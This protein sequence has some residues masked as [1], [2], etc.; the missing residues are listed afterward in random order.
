MKERSIY[1]VANASADRGSTLS[2]TWKHSK[3]N[4]LIVRGKWSRDCQ[5]KQRNSKSNGNKIGASTKFFEDWSG[6]TRKDRIKR[7][8]RYGCLPFIKGDLMLASTPKEIWK[9]T[10]DKPRKVQHEFGGSRFAGLTEIVE[11]LR[12]KDFNINEEYC[13][14]NST[15]LN[16]CSYRGYVLIPNR[17]RMLPTWMWHAHQESFN[18]GDIIPIVRITRSEIYVKE[19]TTE[20]IVK[21]PSGLLDK[22]TE[23]VRQLLSWRTRRKWVIM[24]K[25]QGILNEN[26]S[27][28]GVC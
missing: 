25:S 3:R 16:N 23:N 18:S 1:S 8:R 28:K 26:Y 4:W 17:K 27:I 15:I 19:T 24:R 13:S 7:I 22:I 21:L 6:P 9:C 10:L 11:V 14:V 12:W 5:S 2:A 20:H